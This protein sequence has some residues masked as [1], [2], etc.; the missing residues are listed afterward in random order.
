MIKA[1]YSDFCHI[2]RIAFQ[3]KSTQFRSLHRPNLFEIRLKPGNP[4]TTTPDHISWYPNVMSS[5]DGRV[6]SLRT[7]R[8]IEQEGRMFQ[9][10]EITNVSFLNGEMEIDYSGKHKRFLPPIHRI[11]QY[12]EQAFGA[13]VHLYDAKSLEEIPEWA[14]SCASTRY[15]ILARKQ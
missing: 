7:P 11:R 15:V 1:Q 2:G 4:A 5:G 10:S 3:M 13:E 6:I 14:D 8:L 9:E 12:F